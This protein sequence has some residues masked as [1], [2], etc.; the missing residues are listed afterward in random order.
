[1]VQGAEVAIAVDGDKVKVEA[2]R[3]RYRRNRATLLL[4]RI[5]WT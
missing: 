1:M 5:S 3:V 4:Y 2:S